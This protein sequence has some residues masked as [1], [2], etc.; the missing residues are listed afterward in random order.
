LASRSTTGI[1]EA[2]TIA[3]PEGLRSIGFADLR[4]ER[5]GPQHYDGIIFSY[6]TGTQKPKSWTELYHLVSWTAAFLSNLKN[7]KTSLASLELMRGANEFPISLAKFHVDEAISVI[8][9]ALNFE[10][11]L[12]VQHP[13]SRGQNY[14]VSNIL[15]EDSISLQDI[16]RQVF[17]CLFSKCVVR[18]F[19]KANHY[20]SSV[21]AAYLTDL[22]HLSGGTTDEVKCI[23]FDRRESLGNERLSRGLSPNKNSKLS[24]IS[25]IFKQSDTFAAA[26]GIIESY[27]REQYPNLIVFVEES[28]YERFVK[29][30]QR[31]YSHAVHIGS[32]LDNRTTIVDT[33]NSRVHIDLAAVDIKASHRMPGNV[34]NVLKFR[35]LAELLSL[36]GNF[37]KVPY[38]TIWNEDVLLSREFAL[39]VNQCNEFWLNHVPKSIAGRKFPEDILNFY[40]EAVAEDTTYIYNSVYSQFAEDVE[41]LRKSQ[42]SFMKKDCRLRTTLILQALTSLITRSRSLKNG[43][44]IAES[45][46]RLKRFQQAFSHRIN[47]FE[48]GESRIETISRPTGLAILLVR[49]ENSV[50]SKSLLV[51]FIFKNLIL[52]NA[53]LLVCPV[54]TLGAKFCFE[55]DHILPFKMVHENLPDI[56]KLSLDSSIDANETSASKKQCPKNT[57]ALEILSDMGAG[58]YEA[59][60]L[61]LGSRRKSIWYPDVN[62]TNYW[63]ND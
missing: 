9:S 63:S 7:N 18:L 37:R 45:I 34:I 54:N 61:A 2:A 55:N 38:M 16:V 50:K 6:E 49:E 35:S 40:A 26:Q 31:Y 48:C 62:Q 17:A 8:V 42:I 59:I 3:A 57:Y 22:M 36:L 19:V 11:G 44:T 30:W 46:S 4:L 41:Q 21:L 51:E 25:V 27:F 32:R 20:Y 14:A 13:D 28:T 33:F 24:V 23:A 29:D 58:T 39:R 5:S 12:D 10:L 47:A 43:A 1:E 56:S 60:I 52:G 53:V 15:V